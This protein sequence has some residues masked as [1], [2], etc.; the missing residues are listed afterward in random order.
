V[1]SSGGDCQ[2][3]SPPETMY[4]GFRND[5]SIPRLVGSRSG[6]HVHVLPCHYPLSLDTPNR[7]CEPVSARRLAL[8]TNALSGREHGGGRRIRSLVGC[9]KGTW[10]PN[11]KNRGKTGGGIFAR[12]EER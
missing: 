12:R 5:V 9:K 11:M 3:T 7:E 6:E 1:R 4:G 10:V 8:K 2:D